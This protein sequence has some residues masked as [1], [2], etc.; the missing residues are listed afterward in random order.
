MSPK[1]PRGG[2]RKD[3]QR[4]TI[5]R[6]RRD[7][8]ER[9]RRG[10][11][12]GRGE[13]RRPRRSFGDR[14]EERRPR[15]SFGDRDEERRPRRAMGSRSAEDR[16]RGRFGGRG[17]TQDS[18]RRGPSRS[19]GFGGGGRPGAAAGRGRFDRDRRDR[20]E[21]D[22]DRPVKARTKRGPWSDEAYKTTVTAAPLT[23]AEPTGPEAF[24]GGAES[25]L[26]G[27]GAQK[28][29]LQKVL[30]RS[31]VA[32]RR[33]AEL[34]ILE[35]AVTVNGRTVTELG[36]KVDPVSD[37]IKV[38][39]QMIMTEVEPI[40]MALYKPKAVISALSDPE[41]RQHL[42]DLLRGVRERVVPI[43]RMDYNSE[44]LLLLTNDGKLA[45]KVSK[46]RGIPRIYM[47]KI[48]GHPT[49][50]DLDFLKRGIFT[51]EGVVR[52]ASMGVEQALKNKSWLKLEVTEGASLDLRELLNHRGLLVD[53]IVRTAIGNVT[54][55]GLEPGEFKFMKR[56]D[57]EKLIGE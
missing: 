41:G 54:V 10:F 13:E 18:E 25:A 28:E 20:E 22:F 4:K 29:R 34:L 12:A 39:G 38:N 21:R 47:I 23:V 15:R 2:G 1:T 35:G 30:A 37:K 53:R 51:A 14:D 43:G 9:P 33:K 44:G 8:E 26:P 36:T 49:E 40:Y 17:R 32:S 42:G 57:F 45:E 50:K 55:Q 16:P 11:G 48:K 52:V 31:G 7:A 6:P 5:R 24:G 46:A 3:T 56:Q 27:T 19:G